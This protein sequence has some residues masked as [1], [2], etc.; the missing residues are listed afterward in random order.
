MRGGTDA[1][2]RGTNLGASRDSLYSE[3]YDLVSAIAIHCINSMSLI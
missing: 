1:Q 3:S 2:V